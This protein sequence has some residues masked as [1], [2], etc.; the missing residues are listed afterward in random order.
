MDSLL[1]LARDRIQGCFFPK[2]GR[3]TPKRS[4]KAEMN[5]GEER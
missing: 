1:L 2:I 3:F 5:S 4:E